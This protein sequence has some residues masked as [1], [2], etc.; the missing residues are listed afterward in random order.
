MIKEL[1]SIIIPVFNRENLVIETLNSITKQTYTNWECIIVDDGSTDNT[2]VSVTNYIEK[3]SRFKIF[4]RPSN[5]IKGA[6]SCRNFGFE[7]SKGEY[8]QWFD[9]DDL[10]LPEML[11]KKVS[12][13]KRNFD[14]VLSGCVF[15]NQEK[16]TKWSKD[17]SIRN[18][19]QLDYF[20]N[21]IIFNTPTSLWK[22]NIVSNHK[23]NECL[24]RA[25]ELDFFSRILL[26]E[27]VKGTILNENLVLIREHEQSITGEYLKGDKTKIFND[28][29][30][31]FYI[32][33]ELKSDTPK[34]VKDKIFYLYL[35]T[36]QNA[37]KNKYF[38][39]TLIH[40]F[41]S[42]LKINWSYKLSIL[43]IL[44]YSIIYSLSGKGWEYLKKH[45]KK[46]N[47]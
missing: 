17:L 22:R 35:K 9:S 21:E 19:I 5:K 44:F 40:L 37:L 2:Y 7:Q 36:I 8:I 24:M 28:V 39:K 27:S 38:S 13:I 20:S 25:Q 33:K 3:D 42:F 4:K 10:M 46:Y 11:E 29:N 45:I 16:N 15:F 43:K 30:V 1:V 41:N 23:F 31:R 47:I 18:S 14:F 34:K 32:F 12:K 26:N 6:N